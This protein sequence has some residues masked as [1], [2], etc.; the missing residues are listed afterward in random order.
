MPSPTAVSELVR[1]KKRTKAGKRRKIENR[2]KG[3]VNFFNA[4]GAPAEDDK[5]RA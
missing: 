2:R 5:A 3:T 4:F 1:K